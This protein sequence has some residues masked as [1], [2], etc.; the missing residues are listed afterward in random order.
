MSHLKRST[1]AL[2]T[3][4]GDALLSL[5]QEAIR[6]IVADIAAEAVSPVRNRPPPRFQVISRR[7]VKRGRSTAATTT[8]HL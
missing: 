6:W 5:D 7:H 4:L 2:M 8:I 3:A 1:S